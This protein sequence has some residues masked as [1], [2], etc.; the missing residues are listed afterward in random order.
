MLR[1]NLRLNWIVA[2]FLILSPLAALYGVYLQWTQ[3]FFWQTW[4]LAFFYLFLTGLSIT[5]GY[6]RLYAHKAFTINPILEWPII[7]FGA[8][9]F[10]GS[11]LEWASDHRKHHRYIDTDQDPYSIKKGFWFAHI[12]WLFKLDPSTRDFKNVKDLMQRKGIVLQHRFYN[13]IATFSS[14]I[15]PAAIGYLW[16][17]FWGGLLIAGAFR[18]VCNHHFT[19][20]INSICHTFGKATYSDHM[21]A[22]DHWF[23]ALFTY[24]EGF[25]NFHHQFPN[26][27]RNGIRFYHYDPSKWL[28]R[29]FSMLGLAQNLKRV[30]DT[31][32]LKFRML[33]EEKNQQLFGSLDQKTQEFLI[34]LHNKI[35]S[36]LNMIEEL[37]TKKNQLKLELLKIKGSKMQQVQDKMQN[38]KQNLDDYQMGLKEKRKRLKEELQLWRKVLVY[39]TA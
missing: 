28:I 14:F 35:D 19:F 1:K 36:I 30:P 20:S 29:F 34:H 21:S 12:G 7:F 13:W 23:T 31:K 37:E 15:L 3:G 16:N 32:I 6:H 26:D 27:Y 4:L 18:I 22:K 39:A 10:Q 9:N 25:H 2:I 33:Q 11:I 17:D 8:A 5:V 38:I 24:G